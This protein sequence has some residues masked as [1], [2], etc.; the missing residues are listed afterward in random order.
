MFTGESRGRQFGSIGIHDIRYGSFYRWRKRRPDN[1]RLIDLPEFTDAEIDEVI[2]IVEEV[3]VG[4]GWVE[5]APALRRGLSTRSASS[6][7][8]CP[9]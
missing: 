8:F 5:V 7:T 6:T 4:A 3:L 1:T 2:K 9:R